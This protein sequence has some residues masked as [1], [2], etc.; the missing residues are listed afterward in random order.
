MA[1]F[2]GQTSEEC[3]KNG[4]PKCKAHAGDAHGPDHVGRSTADLPPLHPQSQKGKEP[5][6]TTNTVLNHLGKDGQPKDL[7]EVL[8]RKASAPEEAP[9]VVITKQPISSKVQA[10]IDELTRTIRG[11]AKKPSDIELTHRS[12]SAFSAQIQA[13][14]PMSKYKTPKLPT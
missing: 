12:G 7:R 9:E 11:L 2:T 6:Y 5:A 14:Q 1:D 10:K 4:C 8:N 13:A 3:D